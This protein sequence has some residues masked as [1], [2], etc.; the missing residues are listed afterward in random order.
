M[1]SARLS[2]TPPRLFLLPKP[3]LCLR[4]VHHQHNGCHIVSCTLTQRLLHK[5]LSAQFGRL[6]INRIPL[7]AHLCKSRWKD[8]IAPLV[9][10]QISIA[11]TS[12]QGVF[13]RYT[14]RRCHRAVGFALSSVEIILPRYLPIVAPNRLCSLGCTIPGLQVEHS[15]DLPRS[16]PT[17]SQRRL[18][19][20]R[21]ASR[22]VSILSA[23][24][25]MRQGSPFAEW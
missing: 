13:N 21:T 10:E 18:R 25:F 4:P 17:S 1:A 23:S 14:G 2:T 9:D 11:N 22:R 20:Q 8:Q 19:P 16:L 7:A 15:R 6:L 5:S 24:K 12:P 3:S